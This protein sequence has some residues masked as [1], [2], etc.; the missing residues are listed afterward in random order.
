MQAS[1]SSLPAFKSIQL[2]WL[3]NLCSDSN[4][5][6]NAMRVAGLIAL[7]YV[8]GQ[9]GTTW[10]SFQTLAK[11]LETSVKTIQRA[12]RELRSTNWFTIKR[13]NGLSHNTEYKPFGISILD[14]STRK[15]KSVKI[16]TVIDNKTTKS[17]TAL[18][19]EDGQI[20]PSNLRNEIIISLPFYPTRLPRKSKERKAVNNFLNFEKSGLRKCVLRIIC[21]QSAHLTLFERKTKAKHFAS[22]YCLNMKLRKELRLPIPFPI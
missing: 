1:I 20:C 18:S 9:T 3:G 5:S 2:Q 16:V 11:A 14:A 4:I 10:P 7:K 6:D 21:L 19:L 13:G 17:K 8:N 22:S 12:I 15:E